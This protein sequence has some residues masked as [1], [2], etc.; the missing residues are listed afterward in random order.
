MGRKDVEGWMVAMRMQRKISVF[1]A[2]GPQATERGRASRRSVRNN[3]SLETVVE[4]AESICIVLHHLAH[5]RRGA[6]LIISRAHT[7]CCS[8]GHLVLSIFVFVARWLRFCFTIL[9]SPH[10][11]IGA[12]LSLSVARGLARSQA[13]ALCLPVSERLVSSRDI[14]IIVRI[15]ALGMCM[16]F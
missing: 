9:H 14:Q 7:V 10:R 5:R 16:C 13:P 4:V 6:L 11:S 12:R 1:S 2:Y 3:A 15:G 8:S